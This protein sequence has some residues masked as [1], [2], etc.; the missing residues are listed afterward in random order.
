MS[1]TRKIFLDRVKYLERTKEIAHFYHFNN[2]EQ[3]KFF[4]A[5]INPKGRVVAPLDRATL[6][7][8]PGSNLLALDFVADAFAD[9]DQQYSQQIELGNLEPILGA[10][11]LVPKRAYI[12]PV[13]LYQNHL[14]YLEELFF[15]NYLNRHKDK[16]FLFDDIM[17]YFMRFVED[18]SREEPILFSYFVKS[19]KCPIHTTGLVLESAQSS[20]ND[21]SEKYKI[22]NS[23]DFNFYTK[24]AAR[25]GF[26]IPRHAPWTFVA[27]L[28]S[29]IM[30]DYIRQYDVPDKKSVYREYFYECQG[31]DIDMIRK[32]L[33]DVYVQFSKVNAVK[34]VSKICE[35][36]DK[37]K[38]VSRNVLRP[39][40][41][42]VMSQYDSVYWLK[43]YLHLLMIE[44]KAKIGKKTFDLYFREC[45]SLLQD[46]SFEKAIDY[47][48]MKMLKKR[49]DIYL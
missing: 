24:M 27:N 14:N 11:R 3:K 7:Q 48:E 2:W 36:S 30:F 31:F 23:K 21:N 49:R 15:Q 28:D 29:T 39:P 16:I 9:M 37:L 47:A 22:L 42:H 43:V 25:Y 1:G 8:V 17:F 13:S 33:Y 18:V 34:R 19:S 45:Y 35:K 41:R 40:I 38:T 10:R 6:K 46:E 4:Y 44:N 26:V 5:R 20:H 32:F 12:N